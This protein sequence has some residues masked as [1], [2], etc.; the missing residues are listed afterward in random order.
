MP[1]RTIGMPIGLALLAVM[2]VMAISLLAACAQTPAPIATPAPTI[3]PAP[4]AAP[5]SIA[6]PT[7]VATTTPTPTTSATAPPTPT[8]TPKPKPASISTPAPPTPTPAPASTATPAPPTPIAD[9][10]AA[11]CS[12]GVAVPNPADN[13]ALVSDCAALLAAKST[14]EGATGNLNWAADVGISYWDGVCLRDNRVSA[15]H[16]SE[17]RN[18]YRLNGVIP[19]EL[20]N[21]ANLERLDL[22]GN[23]LT[24][25]I[26]PELGNLANL[27]RLNIYGSDLTGGIPLW[28][29]NLAKLEHLDLA[30]NQ[31]TGAI[32]PG[33]GNLPNLTELHIRGNQLTG[34]IPSEL[35]NLANLKSLW[36]SNNQLTG[37]I[38]SELGNLANLKSLWLSNNQLTGAIPM[39]LG[40]LELGNAYINDLSLSNNQLT[41]CIP[42]SLL[43]HM[44][45][46]E[47]RLIGLPFCDAAGAAPV[48]RQHAEQCSN[49]VAVPNPA[50]NPGL[51]S[52]CANLL[53]ARDTLA[54][55]SAALNWSED[56]AIS[57]W[58]GVAI[59]NNRVREL[60]LSD[61]GLN[62]ELSPALG[63]LDNLTTLD[64]HGNQLTGAIP[65]GTGQP[66]QSL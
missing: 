49:G 57:D 25:E 31:L 20:G 34:E 44:D 17:W 43:V 8:P 15:L 28:L 59:D 22:S 16:L 47:T 29:G 26:P 18:E 4:V 38:P 6:T 54:G 30:Y 63:N 2:S 61:Y 19:A 11:Q 58:G 52:D 48:A 27:K 7:L 64:I 50:D 13:P 56:V 36:L 1:K 35:G 55:E 23:Q 5:A 53:A 39:E 21:L 51:V 46:S 37:A 14:L 24:G 33:L 60:R 42:A 62:G 65:P 45:G 12:N 3:A 9:R 41:G 32:P 10:R 40:D 66:S